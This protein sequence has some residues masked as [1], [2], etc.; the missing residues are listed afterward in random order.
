MDVCVMCCTVR[1]KGKKPGQSGQRSTNRV[2]RESKKKSRRGH[3]CL[4]IV[5]VV[6]DGLITCP[7]ESYRLWCDLVYDLGTSTRRQLKL[8]RVV[9]A[10]C[11]TEEEVD[12]L[13]TI[14]HGMLSPEPLQLSPHPNNTLL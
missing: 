2:Q 13:I 7:E 8:V 12:S 14:M 10:K 5:C 9:N 11:R 3:G 4:S 1:T 6:C